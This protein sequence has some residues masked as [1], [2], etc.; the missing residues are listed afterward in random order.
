MAK[1]KDKLILITGATGQQGGAASRHLRAEGFPIRALTRH[2]DRPK[3]RALVGQGTEVVRGDLTD[4]VSLVRAMDGVYGV[5]GVQTAMEEGVQSETSQGINLADAAK[6]SSVSHLVYSSVGSADRRTGI[7]H[8]DS[9]FR[10]EEHIRGSGL[11]YTILRP[12]FFMENWL[13]MRDGI[14]KGT[15]ALPLDADTRLQMISVD[16][17]GVFVTMAFEHPGHWQGRAVDLAGDEISMTDIAEAF[18]RMVG[19]NV[20]Y[21]QIPWNQFEQTA[22]HDMTLMYRWFQDVGYS[23]DIAALRQEYSNLTRFDRWLQAAWRPKVQTA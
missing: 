15:L 17:I 4:P 18:G 9:K 2:P 5:Y 22:G 10:I 6:R 20:R 8:F 7:P 1:N 13:Y 12:V 21:V 11:R 16:D 14:E 3:A 19:R 23:V